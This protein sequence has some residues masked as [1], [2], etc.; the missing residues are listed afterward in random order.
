M[1]TDIMQSSETMSKLVMGKVLP[2]VN[3]DMTFE[4]YRKISS[5]HVFSPSKG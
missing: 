3:Y 4:M 1:S 5:S 2:G